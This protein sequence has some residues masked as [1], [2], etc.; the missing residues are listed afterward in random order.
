MTSPPRPQFGNRFL[1][2][3]SNVFSHNAWDQVSIQLMFLCKVIMYSVGELIS[4]ISF[5]QVSWDEEQELSA[6]DKVSKNSGPPSGEVSED[7]LTNSSEKWDKFYNIHTNR[8]FKDR[9]WLFTEF[10]ELK[11]GKLEEEKGVEAKENEAKEIEETKESEEK[12]S[13]EKV[14]KTRIMEV[15][16]GVGN[17][18]FPILEH[19]DEDSVFVYGCDFSPTAIDIVQSHELYNPDKCSAFVCDISQVTLDMPVPQNSLDVIT[20]IFVLSAINPND[21]AHCIA[22]LARYLKPGGHV[23]FRD[24][25]R[26]DLAQLRFKNGR[27]LSDN[28]YARGDGTKVY[29]TT[30][31]E[32]DKLFCDAGLVKVQNIVDRR[33]QVNRARKLKMYRVWIQCKY[34]KPFET[35]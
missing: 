32:V 28:F 23:L 12:V 14:E 25:G 16:C 26:Y 27:C 19:C 20:I 18:I 33:L 29:F 1:T 2:D 3:D 13:V 7:L 6:R 11:K 21:M 22:N 9:H 17:T 10:P 31:E 35:V 4:H 34:M 30:Q 5:I 8:F 24:Y 15:G